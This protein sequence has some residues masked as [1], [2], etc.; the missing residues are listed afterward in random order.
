M[1][2]KIPRHLAIIMDG[3][4]RWAE[5][6]GLPRTK[7]HQEGAQR[8]K[9]I[10][11]ACREYGVEVLPSTASPLRIGVDRLLRSAP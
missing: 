7:G 6:R 11:T 8:V 9:E 10:V 5:A 4:G 2:L 3:N 1:T